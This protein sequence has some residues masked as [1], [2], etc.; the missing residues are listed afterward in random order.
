MGNIVY[1]QSPGIFLILFISQR[2]TAV[3][4][5]YCTAVLGQCMLQVWLCLSVWLHLIIYHLNLTNIDLTKRFYFYF[6]ITCNKKSGDRLGGAAMGAP[7]ASHSLSLMLPCLQVDC[8]SSR[9]WAYI[10][11]RK[12]R[13]EQSAQGICQL[14]VS[15]LPSFQI[16][17]IITFSEA[18]VDL[19]L[20]LIGQHDVTWPCRA[21]R[22]PEAWHFF[23]QTHCCAKQN[24]ASFGR[25]NCEW[26]WVCS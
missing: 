18:L 12:K 14:L 19:C 9:S 1:L 3:T 17:K 16:R 26:C 2:F 21:E 6:I 24:Q 15:P 10:L 4:D 8:F 11:C 25:E 7:S 5:H 13:E 20:R 22:K 23:S